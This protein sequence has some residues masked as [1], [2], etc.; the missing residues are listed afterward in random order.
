[1]SSHGFLSRS[2]E[3]G[4]GSTSASIG[5]RSGL[6]YTIQLFMHASLALRMDH[7]TE[8]ENQLLRRSTL[9]VSHQSVGQMQGIIYG[10]GTG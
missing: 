3:I 7:N 10:V 8:Q 1:M 5:S 4:K 2:L 6:N 9:E